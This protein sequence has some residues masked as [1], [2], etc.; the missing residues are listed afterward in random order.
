MFSILLLLGILD[1]GRGLPQGLIRHPVSAPLL[2]HCTFFFVSSFIIWCQPPFLPMARYFFFC[3]G[4]WISAEV[5]RIHFVLFQHLF[6]LTFYFPTLSNLISSLDSQLFNTQRQPSPTPL[7]TRCSTSSILSPTTQCSQ[8]I[9]PH[10]ACLPPDCD[11]SPTTLLQRQLPTQ[12]CE[13]Q[14]FSIISV[15]VNLKDFI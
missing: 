5:C 7:K 14:G 2:F 10:P 3:Y 11:S 4:C 8:Q 1:F 9:P 13:P 6:A 15:V 12:T